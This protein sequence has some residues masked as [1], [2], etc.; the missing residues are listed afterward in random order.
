MTVS[1]CHQW[2]I[3]PQEW[4]DSLVSGTSRASPTWKAYFTTR[5]GSTKISPGGMC[6][7]LPICSA[8]FMVQF[9]SIK[10]SPGGMCLAL[11]IC[12]ACFT[13]RVLSIRHYVVMR[14]SIPKQTKV[15]FWT[16][17]RAQYQRK[18]AV[19]TSHILS[20]WFLLQVATP[21]LKPCCIQF[22]LNSHRLLFQ[23]FYYFS[24]VFSFASL[25]ESERS[26]CRSRLPISLLEWSNRNY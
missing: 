20:F 15:R 21:K 10:I 3:A 19:C 17:R 26:R 23:H 1:K 24:L 6:L 5:V 13:V 12:S 16:V 9:L 18:H 7:T 2:G 4:T 11:P 25:T 14:G 22:P 8:C